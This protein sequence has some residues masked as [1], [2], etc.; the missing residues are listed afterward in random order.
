MELSSVSEY[1]L[2]FDPAS[3]KF[4][5]SERMSVLIKE[6]PSSCDVPKVESESSD[7]IIVDSNSSSEEEDGGNKGEE[8][9]STD[10]SEIAQLKVRLHNSLALR[11]SVHGLTLVSIAL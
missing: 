4:N 11:W 6:S 3:T 1:G 2:T 10:H 9:V 8:N 5:I 7:E